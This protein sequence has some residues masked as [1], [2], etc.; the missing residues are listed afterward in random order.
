MTDNPAPL[1]DEEIGRRLAGLPGWVREVGRMARAFKHTGHD[2]AHLAM[3]VAA[4]ASR[5]A[6]ALRRAPA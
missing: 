1:S 4:E 5:C 6:A 3:P 2:C